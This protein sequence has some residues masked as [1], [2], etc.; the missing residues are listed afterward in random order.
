MALGKKSSENI[1][2]NGEN[3]GKCWYP[4]FSPIPTMFSALWWNNSAIW[5]ILNLSSP[6]AFKSD[7]PRR[8]SL[9]FSQADL[10]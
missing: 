2:G 7:H 8:L 1:L 3:A 4:A 5:A 6:Y 10:G 9:V